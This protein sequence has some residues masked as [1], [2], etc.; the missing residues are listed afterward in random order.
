MAP[1]EDK[2]ENEERAIK[3]D[4]HPVALEFPGANIDPTADVDDDWTIS[5]D[6]IP[7]SISKSQSSSEQIK[8]PSLEVF[9][10]DDDWRSMSSDATTIPPC[11]S[12]TSSKS[13]PNQKLNVPSIDEATIYK[14]SR[15]MLR[16][17]RTRAMVLKNVYPDMRRRGLKLPGKKGKRFSWTSRNTR[18]A[19]LK[20]NRS[21]YKKP[22]DFLR[23]S[24]RG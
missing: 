22:S 14:L 18:I 6:V 2:R 10:E 1:A 17:A 9:D 24:L 23:A 13:N 8:H 12:T 15:T 20:A 11:L 7:L 21:L 3:R 4:H 5:S 16:S 19:L